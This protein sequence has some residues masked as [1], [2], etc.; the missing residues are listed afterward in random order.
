MCAHGEDVFKVLRR[1]LRMR[2]FK[3]AMAFALSACMVASMVTGCG[4]SDDK[5]TSSG[6]DTATTEATSGDDAGKEDSGAGRRRCYQ[7]MGIHR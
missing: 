6:D 1:I 3:R 5:D 4:S 2:K 7:C